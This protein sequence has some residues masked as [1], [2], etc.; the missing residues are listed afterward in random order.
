MNEH[1]RFVDKCKTFGGAISNCELVDRKVQTRSGMSGIQFESTWDCIEFQIKN[2]DN[3][4]V[5]CQIIRDWCQKWFYILLDVA[6]NDVCCSRG[7]LYRFLGPPS[8]EQQ[9]P[10]DYVDDKL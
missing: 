10:T 7:R 6:E 8:C 1:R 4:F 2:V 5:G 9:D 3:C